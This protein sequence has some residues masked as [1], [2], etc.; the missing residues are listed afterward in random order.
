VETISGLPSRLVS[1]IAERPLRPASRCRRWR[2]RRCGGRALPFVHHGAENPAG[3]VSRRCRRRCAHRQAGHSRAGDTNY[4]VMTVPR[5]AHGRFLG[6][7][8]STKVVKPMRSRKAIVRAISG[9][10]NGDRATPPLGGLA[11]AS[12]DASAL[13]SRGG[14]VHDVLQTPG[15]RACHFATA[16]LAKGTALANRGQPCTMRPSRG[17][18]MR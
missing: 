10:R 18:R 13:G 4:S 12:A 5:F 14:Q 11:R 17:I 6:L 8:A 3:S 16:R 1:R 2:P 9:Q 15:I 7:G